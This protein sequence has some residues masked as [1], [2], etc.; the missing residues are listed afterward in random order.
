MNVIIVFLWFWVLSLTST[1]LGQDTLQQDKYGEELVLQGLQNG[2]LL[3]MFCV[4]EVRIGIQVML[5]VE[6]ST[7][8]LRHNVKFPVAITS[9]MRSSPFHSV[10]VHSTQGHW[11]R[12][13]TTLRI[14]KVF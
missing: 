2:D 10:E 13:M 4:Y 14:F 5:S 7:Q 11:V 9:L 8:S 12:K 6:Q 1:V 3:V